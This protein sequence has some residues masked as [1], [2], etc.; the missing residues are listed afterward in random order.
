MK[1]LEGLFRHKVLRML[2]G[3]GRITPET[4]RIMDRWRHSGFNVFCGARIVPREKRSP[5]RLA[6]YLIRSSFSQ[7]R[8]EYLPD[9]ARVRYR[10]KDTKEQKS[11]D[12]QEWLAAMGTHVP[13]RGQKSVRYYGFLSNAARGKR[14]K[15]KQEG[16]DHPE[17]EVS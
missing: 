8:M 17:S 1:A 5:E 12:A 9:Q 2:L 15:D 13:A 16:E 14:G 6:A 7:E 3:K 10:C 11:Y 4:I